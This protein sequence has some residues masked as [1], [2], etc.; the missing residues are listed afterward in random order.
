MEISTSRRI[1][2]PQNFILKFSTRKY[3]RDVTPHANLG[4]DRF[5]GEFSPTT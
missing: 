4:T 3:V 2:I 5:G 1:T